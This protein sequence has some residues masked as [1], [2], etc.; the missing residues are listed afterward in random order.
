MYPKARS[1]I[2]R[3]S[4]L[5][6]AG[7][8]TA[9][10]LVAGCRTVVTPELP[11]PTA[12][13]PPIPTTTETLI[14][15]VP[16]AVPPTA[17]AQTTTLYQVAV[18]QASSYEPGLVYRQ[19][20]AMLDGLGGLGDIIHSGDKVAIKVNLT[21]GNNFKPPVGFSATESYVTHPEVVRALGKLLIDAGAGELWIVEAV[22][23]QESY[24]QWGF[25][26]VAKELNATLV[27]LNSPEPYADFAKTPV[28][29][30]WYLYETFA[31]N[32]ILE[33][34]DAF[35]S[36]AKMKCH[37][38]AGVTL[39]MKNL[40]GL[41]PV[42]QYR[43]NPDH[44]W[45]SALHGNG[46]EARTRLPRIILDLNR[47]RPIHLALIDGIK[48]SEGG[49]APRGSFNP[50][51]PGVLVAGKNALA[52]DAAATAVMGFDPTIAPPT[53]PFI[54]TENYL[55]MA[56]E[57]G[58]GSNLLEEIAVVGTPIEKVRYPFKPSW[59]Q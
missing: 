4:F 7:V 56:R 14:P 12:T 51:Q 47:A 41:L 49:E 54:R 43:Q 16:A 19:V 37:W 59:E 52:T 18:A 21:G 36:V 42:S 3:R 24:P 2:S 45:R 1:S 17:A 38:N 35:I 33:E 31:F 30:G 15:T 39:S 57:L 6:L 26:A 8:Y 25:Q 40:I 53:P 50:V 11:L 13:A 28:G 48:T 29:E 55:N 9:G 20:Q 44:W 22:Y 58:L 10:A 32:R 5:R 23:D 46:D 27:D 34:A